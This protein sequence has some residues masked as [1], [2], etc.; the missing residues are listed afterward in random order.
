MSFEEKKKQLIDDFNSLIDPEDRF[1]YIIERAKAEKEIS[2]EYKFESFKV[3]GCL[4]QLW[5][6]PKVNE[7]GNC[8]FLCDGDALIPKGI[9]LIIL[10]LFQDE[11]KEV[12][13]SADLS[14]LDNLGLKEQL[15]PNRRNALSK[16]EEYVKN[17]ARGL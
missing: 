3:K 13:I 16:I 10:D 11:K 8:S 4:S 12:V 17:F 14:F 2:P 15:T 9:A 7:S 5:I 1:T 6:A